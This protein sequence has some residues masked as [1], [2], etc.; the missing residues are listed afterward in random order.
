MPGTERVEAGPW[1]RLRPALGTIGLIAVISVLMLSLLVPRRQ[2]CEHQCESWLEGCLLTG[3]RGLFNCY[4]AFITSPARCSNQHAKWLKATAQL[5]WRRNIALLNYRLASHVWQ[6]DHNGFIGHVASKESR[7][8]PRLPAARR[9]DVIRV[10][11][12]R[13]AARQA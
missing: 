2:V 11:H 10:T 8:C 3:G 9:T 12:R 7:R 4:E 1:R 6:Q 13:S 5:P